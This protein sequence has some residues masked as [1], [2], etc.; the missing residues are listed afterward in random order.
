MKLADFRRGM[1]F[2]LEGEYWQILQME[3]NT[4]GNKRSLYQVEMKNVKRGN[5]LRKRMSPS[6]DLEDVFTET[7]EMEFLY[8]EGESFVMMDRES[9][10]QLPMT[11]D[12]IGDAA[13]Y[14][15]HNEVVRVVML[16]HEPVA[17]DL[18]AAVILG[19]TH[20]E[21]AARGDTVSNVTKPATLET[22]LEIRVPPH[23]NV[24]DTVKVDTRTGQFLGR[25]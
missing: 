22:G 18:P 9:Y 5:V 12:Q 16:D 13:K 23:I 6:D 10:D 11:A 15:K 14:M 7:K 8:K 3:L 2:K 19:V 17:I 21:P 20:T 24:G 25:A 4:P 1:I